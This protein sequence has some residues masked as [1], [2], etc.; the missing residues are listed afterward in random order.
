MSI[1]S[2]I[3]SF[4]ESN[5][6]E[7][8][9]EVIADVEKLVNASIP[10]GVTVLSKALAAKGVVVDDAFLTSVVTDFVAGVE[11]KVVS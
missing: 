9:K 5:E 3:K 8:R 1:L 4:F 6:T 10:E 2:K 11:A 7:I